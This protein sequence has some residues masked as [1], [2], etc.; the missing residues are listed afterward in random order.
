MTRPNPRLAKLHRD[1][2]EAETA[3]LFKVHRNTVR[4][5]RKRGLPAIDD[6]RPAMIRGKALRTF[7]ETERAGSKRPCP[8]GTIFCCKCRAPQPPTA[9][10]IVFEQARNGLG[11]L[12]ALCAQ[13]GTRMFQRARQSSLAAKLPGFAIQVVEASRHIEECPSPSPNSI[14]QED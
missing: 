5:W 12:R 4:G 1:Y 7:L 9:G 2:T 11:N 8:P 3:R 14:K 6:V 13:C 10:S